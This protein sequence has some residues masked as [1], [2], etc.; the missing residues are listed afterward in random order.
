[1]ERLTG[2]DAAFLYIETPSAHMH[3]A[4]TGIYDVT[5]MEGGYSFEALKEHIRSRL[6]L[7]PPFR[8]RLVQVPFQFHH[9]VWVEDPNFNLDYHVRRIG[10][11]APGGRRELAEVAAQIASI[12][13]DRTRPLWEAWVIE[14]LKH[15]RIG[16]VVKVHHSAIDGASGAEIMTEMYDLTP[17]GRGLEPQPVE[18]ERIPT[19]QEL[20]TYAALS[21]LRLARDSFGLL[22]RTVDSV[23]SLVRAA[24]DPDVIHGAVPLTAPRT[25][26]N[27]AIGP[28]RAVS[29][30]RVPL[31]QTK[32]VKDAL[33]VKLNDVILALCSGTL[34]RYLAD[35]GGVP[36]EP[37]VATC[38]VSVR[39]DDE[40]GSLGNKVSAMFTSL[41]TDL[42]DPG[43]RLAAIC[44][45]TGGAKSDHELVGARTLTDWAE[46]AAPRTF[47]LASRLY[48]SMNESLRPVHNLVISNVPGP[49]FPLYLGGAELVAAYPMGPI[50]DGAGLNITVLSYRE[51]IDIGFMADRELVPD[52][53]ELA[54]AVRPAFEEL[55]ALAEERDPTVTKSAAPVTATSKAARKRSGTSGKSK[56]SPAKGSSSNGSTRKAPSGKRAPAKRVAKRERTSD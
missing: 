14:G 43:D 55:L 11:P 13:L 25:P 46:W 28:H 35:H 6:H 26:W 2:M 19:D 54:E 44:E 37:L 1:M 31:E 7:V 18:P 27:R 34:R 16:F 40:K 23:S 8:R 52:V 20:L 45:S 24:R 4:M 5:T 21:K 12:P 50:M 47:G 36:E 48:G 17:E 49:P 3:V 15:D 53:W 10:C 33:G 51:H 38:P 29:F 41:A 30:A 42:E 22:K 32:A 56:K 39:V 9:P